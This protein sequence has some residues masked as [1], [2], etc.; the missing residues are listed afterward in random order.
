MEEL[1]AQI[2]EHYGIQAQAAQAVEELAELTVALSKLRRVAWDLESTETRDVAEEI[3]DVR[4][5]L[6]QLGYLLDCQVLSEAYYTRKLKRQ[7]KRMKDEGNVTNLTQKIE[8]RIE[9]YKSQEDLGEYVDVVAGLR[10]AEELI[11]LKR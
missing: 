8:E 4:I 10:E 11:N 7:L 5:M 9:Y 1:I 6:D 2:A 3:A